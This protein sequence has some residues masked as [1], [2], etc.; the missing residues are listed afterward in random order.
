MSFVPELVMIVGDQKIYTTEEGNRL[1][2]EAG[3][4]AMTP[5]DTSMDVIWEQER[6]EEEKRRQSEVKKL[7][8]KIPDFNNL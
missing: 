8:N 2:H 4:L 1:Y 3:R 7:Y 6:I 5:C